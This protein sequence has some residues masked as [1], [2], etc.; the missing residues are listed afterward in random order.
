MK[1]E[2]SLIKL[3]DW[4]WKQA[5]KDMEG[6]H[7]AMGAMETRLAQLLEYVLD[8]YDW[9]FD[10]LVKMRDEMEGAEEK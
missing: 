4:F 7:T 5:E 2:E 10:E 6:G 1:D 8:I 9:D 3:K